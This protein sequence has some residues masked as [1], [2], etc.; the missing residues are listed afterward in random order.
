MLQTI[1][2]AVGIAFGVVAITLL[3]SHLVNRSKKLNSKERFIH[4]LLPELDCGK[5][6]CPTCEAFSKEIANEEVEAARCPYIKQANLSK[7]QRVI[8]KGYYNNGNLVAF[9]KCK[10]GLDCKNKFEYKGPDCCWCKENLHSGDKACH[11]ACLGCG[12]CVNVCRY[13]ALFINEKGVAQVNRDKCT[14]CG[15]CTYV[16][17]NHLIIRIPVKQYVNVV[18]DNFRDKAAISNKCKVGCTSCGLCAKTC[19]VKAIKMKDGKPVIDSEK[20]IS[21][22]KCVGVCPNQ[23]I[24]RF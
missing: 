22:D 11:K 5:C 16:C 18:C 8:K 6:G 9:V 20:C 3:I 17:P 23:V 19:P 15:A 14:G 10:G 24:S 13:G 7:I 12:D 21:C 2:I 4:D 1:L